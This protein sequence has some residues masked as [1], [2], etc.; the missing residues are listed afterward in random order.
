MYYDHVT[1]IDICSPVTISLF[2]SAKIEYL[3]RSRLRSH[4]IAIED[5]DLDIDLD[6]RNSI[7][8]WLSLIW[9][10]LG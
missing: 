2:Q 4:S 6:D 3:E 9:K 10:T 8:I 7:D 1:S 5:R